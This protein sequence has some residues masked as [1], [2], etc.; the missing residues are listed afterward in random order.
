[1]L[2]TKQPKGIM[3]LISEG[4]SNRELVRVYGNMSMVQAMNA[5]QQTI[6]A[7]ARSRGSAKVENT[8]AVLLI[9]TAAYF[10][11]DMGKEQ[12]ID[13]AVEITTKF[14]WIKME[15]V[16]VVLSDVRS[17]ETFGK[18]TSNKLLSA[19]RRYGEQRMLVAAQQSLNEHLARQE[20]RAA[21]TGEARFAEVKHQWE[22]EKFKKSMDAEQKA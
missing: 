2:P 12:A 4:N 13:I 11:Q 8:L 16:W 15:D 17:S 18:L 9:E 5:P 3:Q 10:D 1:M 6:G 19:L 20:S 22:L 14:N 7:L 21:T